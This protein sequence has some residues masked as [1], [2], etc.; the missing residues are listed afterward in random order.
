MFHAAPIVFVVDD[1]MSVR[2]SLEIVDPDRRLAGGD[3]RVRQGVSSRPAP[4]R[5][6][7]SGPG[8]ALRTINGLDLQKRHGADRSGHADHLHHRP[9]RRTDVGPGMKAGAVEFLTKP[10]GDEA[11]LSA[12]RH[13]I[14][15][16]HSALDDEAEI[17]TIRN[18]TRHSAAVN[19]K[20]CAWW[21][22]GY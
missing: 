3:L 1:D 22:P 5:P 21:S 6:E 17:R 19:A 10:F 8:R 11:L 7:L 2:E 16:S 4:P 12:I 18:V 14:E 13:A 15:R 9:R 20:S